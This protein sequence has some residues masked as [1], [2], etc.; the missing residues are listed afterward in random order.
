MSK[1]KATF[2][3]QRTRFIISQNEF[4]RNP[5]NSPIFFLHR[6]NA[7]IHWRRDRQPAPS[8]PTWQLV[9]INSSKMRRNARVL[10]GRYRSFRVGTSEPSGRLKAN[11]TRGSTDL[12]SL[13]LLSLSLL[14][15]IDPLFRISSGLC[16]Y[17]H[18]IGTPIRCAYFNAAA[19]P[20]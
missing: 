18:L 20:T 14:Y 4:L 12:A 11:H 8:R 19:R 7:I 1:S 6:S 3:F 9:P 2:H 10:C 5:F 15:S 16:T 13:T 17:A